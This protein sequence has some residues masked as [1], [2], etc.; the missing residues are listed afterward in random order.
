MFLFLFVTG[1]FFMKL[2]DFR[3]KKRMNILMK[4]RK[5]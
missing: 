4:L 2:S 1:T 3:K 5:N